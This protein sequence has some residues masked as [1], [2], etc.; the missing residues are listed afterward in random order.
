MTA[1][2][3]FL[4]NLSL[5]AGRIHY[6]AE[7]G[8]CLIVR[9]TVWYAIA[10]LLNEMEDDRSLGMSILESI[11]SEDRTH[12]PATM[13]AILHQFGSQLTTT[14]QENLR[15]NIEQELVHAA[16]VE[17]HD[18]NVN[19]PLG[20][21]CTLI[22]GGEISAQSWATE[23]GYRKLLS[24]RRI[25]GDRQHRHRRQAE[26]SEYNSLTYTA[27][28][29][30]FLAII[31]EYAIHKEAKNLALFLEQQLWIDIAMHYHAPSQQFAGPHSRSYQEDST[32]G[33][34][35]LHCT[36][37]AA[38]GE[39]IF[40]NPELS[41]QFYHPSNLIQNSLIAIIQFHPPERAGTIAFRKP[42]PFYMQKTTYC[43]QYHENRKRCDDET[44]GLPDERKQ[45]DLRK[46]PFA[47]DDEV[48]PGGWRDLTTYMTEEYALGT[49]SLPYVN[50]GQSD[51]FMLRI[52]RS[53]EIQNMRDFRSLYTRGV[54]NDSIPGQKNYCHVAQSVIDESYLYE[55]GRCT[56]YQHRNRAIVC[57]APKRT[58][59][60]GICSFRLDLI[61][62]YYAPFDRL[63]I[64]EREISDAD[65][66]VELHHRARIFFQDYRTYSV[67]IPLISF[68][69]TD[70]RGM[71]IWKAND[72]L[73]ISLYNYDGTAV[74]LS[75]DEVNRWR[76]GFA[77]ELATAD[78][79]DSFE[80]F[81]RY[82][83]SIMIEELPNNSATRTIRI[84]SGRD[85]MELDYDPLREMILSR[86]WNGEEERIDHLYIE[87]AGTTE[88]E[89]CPKTIFGKEAWL[90]FTQKD[91]VT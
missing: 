73:M 43:E 70:E 15:K 54:F 1:P 20:A 68:P 82:A 75:R 80:Q 26:L 18:G 29:L 33:F 81:V 13:I 79:F 50:G 69:S 42:F 74:N 51:S 11:R 46:Q 16:S 4:L 38:F 86:K 23:L 41:R 22:C 71:R 8:L 34:S 63:R 67:I 84:K 61:V 52:R 56:S 72:H 64:D 35:A 88:G 40:L 36:M 39:L 78:D 45:N 59:H 6:D 27:L 91:E 14:A 77:I 87:A 9:D 65:F 3:K 47:F 83:S 24:F 30:W 89:F 48:Y 37:F 21:Y 17:W 44:T 19:H 55:E 32:G 7:T 10:L 62:G 12:T 31:A 25:I 53:A 49:S 28:D 2:Q 5:E 57:Y 60:L 66:P 76:N 90:S 58:G 85:T